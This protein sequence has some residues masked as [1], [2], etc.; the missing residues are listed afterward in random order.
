MKLNHTYFY[1]PENIENNAK[2][3]Q[4]F[5]EQEISMQKFKML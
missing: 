4:E 1:H 3:I 2:I 5:E